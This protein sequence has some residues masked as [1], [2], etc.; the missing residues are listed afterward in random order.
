MSAYKQP[1]AFGANDTP[2]CAECKSPMR[3][4]RRTP[5]PIYG[6]DFERQTFECRTCRHE[7]ERS[8]DCAGELV[9]VMPSNLWHPAYRILNR[10]LRAME[11][12]LTRNSLHPS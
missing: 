1:V 10:A 11:D 12:E 3:V 8:A 6:N 4:I 9:E 2:T 7:V 5:H